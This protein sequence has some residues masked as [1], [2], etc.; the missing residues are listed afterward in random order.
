MGKGGGGTIKMGKG[1]CGARERTG[2]EP[3]NRKER[4]REKTRV[5]K[6][7]DRSG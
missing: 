4:A 3:W 2:V 7:E 5:G 1:G 6:G